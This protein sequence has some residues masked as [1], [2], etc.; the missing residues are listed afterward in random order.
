MAKL[1]GNRKIGELPEQRKLRQSLDEIIKE[2]IGELESQ[3]VNYFEEE[4]VEDK[5]GKS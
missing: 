4:K 5:K 2:E 1:S 3:H